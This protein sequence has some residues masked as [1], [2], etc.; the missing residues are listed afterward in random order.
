MKRPAQPK[1]CPCK[2]CP[3]DVKPGKLMCIQCWRSVPIA[4]RAAVYETWRAYQAALL[5]ADEKPDDW[6][7]ARRAYNAARDAAIAAV[8]GARGR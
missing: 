3:N 4:L 5:A 1:L 6:P 8:D 2:D 7:A